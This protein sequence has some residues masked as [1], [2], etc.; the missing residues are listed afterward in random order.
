MDFL[1]RKSW[2]VVVLCIKC[3]GGDVRGGLDLWWG[4]GK[5]KIK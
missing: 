1:Q 5:T 3:E 4:Q 2:R